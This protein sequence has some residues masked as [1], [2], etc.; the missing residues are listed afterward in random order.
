[1]ES[2][3]PSAR[4][5]E[6]INLCFEVPRRYCNQ[7]RMHEDPN[8]FVG[9]CYA[10]LLRADALYVEQDRWPFKRWATFKLWN[11]IGD[12]L[13]TVGAGAMMPRRAYAKGFTLSSLNAHYNRDHTEEIGDRLEDE[14]SADPAAGAVLDELRE[15]I[16]H[17]LDANL[18]KQEALVLRLYHLH[19][20]NNR[21]IGEILLLTESRISQ[22]Q[23]RAAEKLREHARNPLTPATA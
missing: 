23:K 14:R 6:H 1:M 7:K 13:R 16:D 20:F 9:V 18:T 12:E 17:L 4:V 15:S 19:H 11:A 22:V 2:P 10:A 5:L 3:E 21:E 8:Q